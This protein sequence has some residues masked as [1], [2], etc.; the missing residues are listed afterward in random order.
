MPKQDLQATLSYSGTDNAVTV[1]S[2]AA[3]VTSKWGYAAEGDALGPAVCTAQFDN[4]SGDYNPADARSSLYGLIG[5]NTPATVMVGPE[6]LADGVV[7]SWAPDREVK[8]RAWTDVRIVGPLERVNAS[9]SVFS[10]LRRTI[11]AMYRA[12]EGPAAYWPMEGYQTQPTSVAAGI[13]GVNSASYRLFT[14]ATS[15]FDWT[16]DATLPGSQNLPVLENNQTAIS[17]IEAQVSIAP[18]PGFGFGFWTRT[19]VPKTSAAHGIAT[20]AKQTFQ[21]GTTA[22]SWATELITYPPGS[23]SASVPADGEVVASLYYTTDGVPTQTV[24]VTDIEY[25]DGW[26]FMYVRLAQS[27][28]DVSVSISIDGTVVGTGTVTGV[29]LA[30]LGRASMNAATQ[31]TLTEEVG[32]I[33]VGHSVVLADS[34]ADMD[35]F[36][37][38]MYAAGLGYVGETCE[39]RFTRLCEEH[40]IVPSIYGGGSGGMGPQVPDTLPNLL[41]EIARTDGGLIYDCRDF[42]ELE[43]RTG[44]SLVNQLPA[45]ALTYGDNVAPP[46]KPIT[47]TLGVA[48]D[49][50]A[51]SRTGAVSRVTRDEGPFNVNDPVDDPEGI[52]RIEGRIDV[53][54]EDDEALDNAAGWYLR[55]S[56]WPGARYQNVTVD[57]G[58]NEDLVSDVMAMRPGDLITIDELDADTVELLALGATDVI[59]SHGRW[60]T[61]VCVPAGP[62]HVA[63]LDLTGANRIGS[64]TSTLASA[65]NA[66]VGTSMSVTVT[67]SLW[68]TTPGLPLHVRVGGA[69]V[70]VTAI[71]GASS[72]QTFTVDATTVNGVT[73]TVAAGTR[74]DVEPPIFVG[75]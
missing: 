56:T 32:R 39:D 57:L 68:D 49:V 54:P 50:V 13:P 41:A 4:E 14:A 10:A 71:A 17:G 37:A 9:K 60:V 11:T 64:D 63:E 34:T 53:S 5:L 69:V 26:R 46:L 28:A 16:G 20:I 6:V 23:N 22:F 52:G 25:V 66:G 31:D 51:T 45:L 38:A 48:N 72:P 58:T 29:T 36:A 33:S 3:P 15:A 65:F 55:K 75:L 8:G 73:G 61:F 27:G 59:P 30:S 67:G 70:N 62:Y 35:S 40:G 2:E 74:V 12:G 21:I 44:A 7:A 42:Y 47:D 18:A 24:Q 19:A 43:F 1:F